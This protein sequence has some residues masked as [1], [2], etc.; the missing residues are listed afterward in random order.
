MAVQDVLS[1]MEVR[2]V[3]KFADSV[4]TRGHHDGTIFTFMD[5]TGRTHGQYQHNHPTI[6]P[7]IG[8]IGAVKQDDAWYWVVQ[9]VE[10]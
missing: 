5:R 4:E 6:S 7:P 8:A 3:S 10:F 2:H 9:G 1:L